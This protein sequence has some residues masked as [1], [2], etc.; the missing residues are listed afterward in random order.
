VLHTKAVHQSRRKTI[1]FGA[2]IHPLLWSVL[3]FLR[4][5]G[6]CAFIHYCPVLSP[7]SLALSPASL[8]ARRSSC[9]TF[10]LSF[11]PVCSTGSLGV[12]HKVPARRWSRAGTW[13]TCRAC[14]A[15]SGRSAC[16]P[17]SPG[18]APCKQQRMRLGV[19]YKQHFTW[20]RINCAEGPLWPMADVM[21]P[22]DWV[23]HTEAWYP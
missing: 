2:A 19:A 22:D 20:F 14:S 23:L 15:G 21:H 16:T 6:R 5:G 17:G 11:I 1:A 4:F 7:T 10:G 3:P 8:M 12:D 18:S 9:R 13:S